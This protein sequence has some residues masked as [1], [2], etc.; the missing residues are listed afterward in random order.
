MHLEH[1]R[2]LSPTSVCHPAQQGEHTEFCHDTRL[3]ASAT[4]QEPCCRY[5]WP[6]WGHNCGTDGGREPREKDPLQHFIASRRANGGGREPRVEPR[7]SPLQCFLAELGS[8]SS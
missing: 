3:A 8:P 4:T 2:R 7:D 5:A 6:R 1:V